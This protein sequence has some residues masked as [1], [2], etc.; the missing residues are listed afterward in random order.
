MAFINLGF[1]CLIPPLSLASIKGKN[2][3]TNY[4]QLEGSFT[5]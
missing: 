3:V 5:S 2:L 4:T 1:K